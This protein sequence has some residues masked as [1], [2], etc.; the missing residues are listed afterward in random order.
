MG[1]VGAADFEDF[2]DVA[3]VDAVTRGG[4]G[5]AGENGEGVAG[6][7]EGGAAVVGVSMVVLAD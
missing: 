3:G 4:A 6:D 7:G 1:G 5:V 2:W